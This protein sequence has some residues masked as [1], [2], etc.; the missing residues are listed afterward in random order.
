MN[1]DEDEKGGKSGSS[2]QANPRAVGATNQPAK[3]RTA[4]KRTP[5]A[6]K[7]ANGGKTSS[8]EQASPKMLPL[9]RPSKIW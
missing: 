7:K 6:A 8:S 2:E 1:A 3:R 9:A 4:T 5:A